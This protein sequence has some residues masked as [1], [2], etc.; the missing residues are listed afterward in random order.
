MTLENIETIRNALAPHY[1]FPYYALIRIH[2]RHYGTIHIPAPFFNGGECNPR[3]R[4]AGSLPIAQ[5]KRDGEYYN[6]PFCGE[7]SYYAGVC[8]ICEGDYDILAEQA[9]EWEDGC[10]PER[11]INQDMQNRERRRIYQNHEYLKAS[12]KNEILYRVDHQIPDLGIIYAEIVLSEEPSN[13][14]GENH[15]PFMKHMSWEAEDALDRIEHEIR[16]NEEFK[17]H[18]EY[19]EMIRKYIPDFGIPLNYINGDEIEVEGTDE[20]RRQI[21]GMWQHKHPESGYDYWHPIARI[22]KGC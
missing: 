3:S 21:D 11:Y 16:G 15:S 22:H 9:D 8:Q 6:C 10:I 12:V 17:K 20:V 1:E 18:V 13:I 2:T 5:D 7:P 14:C 19:Q 4:W